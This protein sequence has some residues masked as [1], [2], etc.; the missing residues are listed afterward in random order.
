MGLS[1]LRANERS[2]QHSFFFC[3]LIPFST[4]NGRSAIPCGRP[5][6]APVTLVITCVACDLFPEE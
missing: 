1:R 5:D 2:F 6:L 4:N 3:S